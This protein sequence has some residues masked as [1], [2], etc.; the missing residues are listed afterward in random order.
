MINVHIHPDTRGKYVVTVSDPGQPD[1]DILLSSTS[2]GYENVAHPRG[3]VTR[4]FAT[5]IANNREGRDLEDAVA[6]GLAPEPVT[7]F[8]TYKDGTTA[9][10]ERIR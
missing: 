3:I 1:D 4:L 6:V 5:P 8:V 7:L 10:P 9:E 2:Q